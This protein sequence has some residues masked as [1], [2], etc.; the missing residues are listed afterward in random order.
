MEAY[1]YDA[2][3]LVCKAIASRKGGATTGTQIKDYLDGMGSYHG[4][5]G[6]IKFDE[7]GDVIRGVI[8]KT[9]KDGHFVPYA[10]KP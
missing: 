3:M 1:S 8:I 5:T 4:V 2:F 10:N 7:N 6:E 9:I